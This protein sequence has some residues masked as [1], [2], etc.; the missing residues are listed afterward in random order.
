[1]DNHNRHLGLFPPHGGCSTGSFFTHAAPIIQP[2][3]R[4]NRARAIRL[5]PRRTHRGQRN[6]SQV[7][8][9]RRKPLPPSPICTHDQIIQLY[10]GAGYVDQAKQSRDIQRRTLTERGAASL[11]R[12]SRLR[13]TYA[14]I[15][16]PYRQP[17]IYML[18]VDHMR[19]ARPRILP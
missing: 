13:R 6:H 4:G 19:Q 7:S 18:A 3:T 12:L 9:R 11:P 14:P 1:M 15:S 2:E 10:Q 17:S 5:S 8:N 16:L